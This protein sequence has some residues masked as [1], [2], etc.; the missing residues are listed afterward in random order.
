MRSDE[1][2]GDAILS[3]LTR[4]DGS[5]SLCG[6]IHHRWLTI[7]ARVKSTRRCAMY[8]T[9]TPGM[10]AYSY[11]RR[12]RDA[13]SAITQSIV[14][15][16]AHR[17]ITKVNTQNVRTPCATFS[18]W[19]RRP[20]DADADDA[21]RGTRAN[22]TYARHHLAHVFSRSSV[23]VTMH[24]SARVI[25]H[26][27]SINHHE[28]PPPTPTTRLQ[29]DACDGIEPLMSPALAFFADRRVRV[30]PGRVGLFPRHTR[31]RSRS[32]PRLDGPAATATTTRSTT[33]PTR[34]TWWWR[35]VLIPRARRSSSRRRRCVGGADS[36]RACVRCHAN[37]SSSLTPCARA[38]GYV[39][40]VSSREGGG[41]GCARGVRDDGGGCGRVVRAVRE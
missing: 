31:T 19:V 37:P 33:R 5:R 12:S 21:S 10:R 11:T 30:V 6:F 8:R 14:R 20:A 35:L 26:H 2:A 18:P 4:C 3:T 13:P 39:C 38:V 1:F 36:I 32:R 28:Y 29:R 16:I 23:V 40:A 15:S 25:I 41:I 24:P 9:K 34:E 22:H 7:V 27:H 17:S